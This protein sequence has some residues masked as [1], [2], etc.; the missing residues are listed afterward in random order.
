MSLTRYWAHN[1]HAHSEDCGDAGCIEV[2]TLADVR[3]LVEPVLRSI[4]CHC[5]HSQPF[6]S[7]EYDRHHEDWCPYP[8]V[9]R[10]LAALKETP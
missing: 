7:Q 1:A 3:A 10:F 8:R 4:H 9:Q 6:S 2:V 5:L